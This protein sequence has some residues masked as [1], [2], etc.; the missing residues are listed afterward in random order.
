MTAGNEALERILT[1]PDAVALHAEVRAQMDA[2]GIDRPRL[3]TGLDAID[4]DPALAR[5]G[6]YLHD[7]E[8]AEVAAGTLDP[9]QATQVVDLSACHRAPRAPRVR[10]TLARIWR[11]LGTR[12]GARP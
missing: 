12:I 5:C 4:E 9:S 10:W 1:A 3:T 8:A 6:R 11:Y 7:D 2:A